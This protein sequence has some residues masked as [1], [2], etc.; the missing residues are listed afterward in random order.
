MAKVV[1]LTITLIVKYQTAG[2]TVG[3]GEL[4]SVQL[5]DQA[6]RPPKNG[7]SL[8]EIYKWLDK[9][10]YLPQPVEFKFLDKGGAGTRRRRQVYRL[11]AWPSVR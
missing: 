10:C 9:K 4:L 3:A 6:A 5:D 11:G 7:M 1:P 2:R 8:P